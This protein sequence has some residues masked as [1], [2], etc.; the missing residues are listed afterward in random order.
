MDSIIGSVTDKDATLK[1][2]INMLETELY[3]SAAIKLGFGF[4][5]GGGWDVMLNGSWLPQ[6]LVDWV[7]SLANS[8]TITALKPQLTTF[9]IGVKVRKTLLEDK[10]AVP[11]LSLGLGYTIGYSELGLTVPSMKT[12]SGSDLDVGFGKLNLTGNLAF[13]S[14]VHSVGFDLHISKHLSVF[15]PF[16]KLS[17]LY[18]YAKSS[19]NANLMATITPTSV[20]GSTLTQAIASNPATIV[21]DFTALATLGFE[22]DFVVIVLDV[23]MAIDLQRAKFALADNP[24]GFKGNGVNV[25]A[26]LRWVF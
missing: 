3:P 1:K 15:T 8:P 10:D 6:A 13:Q 26:G 2:W 14:I 11:A 21:S 17:G 20:G 4:G 9:N 25:N 23:N 16:I 22:L 7:V 12:L 18:E 24:L 5:L 19:A